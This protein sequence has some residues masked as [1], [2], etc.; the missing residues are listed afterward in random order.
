[1]ASIDL[2]NL[3]KAYG[4]TPPVV[5]AINL[6]IADG[7]F[8]IFLG[9][10]G[11]GKSTTLRMIAGLETVTSGEVR[12]DGAVV[13]DLDP[14]KR[15]LA[16]VFQNY[17]L[18]PHM[19]VRKNLAFGLR[20]RHIPEAE[21]TRR[22]QD[23]GEILGLSQLLDRRPA[24]LSGGQRQRVALGRALVREPKAF[25]LDEPL[26][27]LDAKLRA[28]MR[29][30]L[31]KLHRRLGTTMIHV[32]HDQVEAMTMGQRICI[33]RD[34]EI[35]QVGAPLEVYRNPANLFVADFLATPPMNLLPGRLEAVGEDLV[36]VAGALRLPIPPAY[37]PAYAPLS[38]REVVLGLRPEDFHPDARRAGPLAAGL[39]LTV[40]T[41]EALGPEQILVS[42]VDG[43]AKDIA[44]RT[45][46]ALAIRPGA[47]LDLSYDTT[48]IHLFDPTT[49]LC[50]TRPAL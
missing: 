10:S 28:S 9:P 48:K 35:M 16:I 18:Y 3:S 17:A 47:R 38:G 6:E 15:D 22:I 40:E 30:E 27:N 11:C 20:L 39:S 34:G 41:V 46:S 7:E 44:V 1:M 50:L 43:C 49:T 36:A 12:I 21:I 45:E 8:M 13:N 23:V 33:M 24:H 2:R 32:T 37:R 31:I 25:L 29:T 5:R 42:R 4:P 19:S 14:A 26:S